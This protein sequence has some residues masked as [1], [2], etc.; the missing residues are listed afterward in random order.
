[1]Y[2]RMLFI[3]HFFSLA[4]CVLNCVMVNIMSKIWMGKNLVLLPWGTLL[5]TL[6]FI[7][8]NVF[9]NLL[10]SA[11]DLPVPIAATE[12]DTSNL[13]FVVDEKSFLINKIASFPDK[14]S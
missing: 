14:D 2:I 7:W 11:I 13:E 4:Q 1:M 5:V 6:S 12:L 8:I 10:T 9:S 3:L